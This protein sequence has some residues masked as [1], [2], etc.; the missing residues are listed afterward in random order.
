MSENTDEIAELL[1]GI[2]ARILV[3][4]PAD[5]TPHARLH[6]DL[7]ADSLDFAELGMALEDELGLALAQEDFRGVTTV[8]DVAELARRHRGADAERT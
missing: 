7:G 5:V 2:C 6:E 4:D 8:G 3:V 1:R